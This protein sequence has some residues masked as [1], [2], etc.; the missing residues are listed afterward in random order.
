MLSRFCYAGRGAT[1]KKLLCALLLCALCMPASGAV[2]AQGAVVMDA[3]TG[4]VLFEQNADARLPM[5]STTKIMTAL[6]ALGEGNL[7]RTYTVKA[8]YAQVE[9]SSMYLREGETLTLRDTLYGLML[10]SGNDAAVA[11]AG[12]CGG[13]GNFVQKMNDK[14]VEL[15]LTDTHFDNPNGLPGDTHYTTA[16][17]LAKI[18][19]AALRDPV[20]RQIVST[21]TYT[22]GERTLSN[23]NRL[24]SMYDGAIGVKTG[25]TR[26]AGRC[27]V[28]AAERNGRTLIA[29]T[30]NDPDDWNDHMQMLDAGFAQYEEV[31]LHEAG[32]EIT[33]LRVFG[34]DVDSVPLLAQNTVTAYLLPGEREK[35]Q[36]VRYGE[37]ICYAPVV[38]TAHAGRIEY[39]I[40]DKVLA[41]DTLVYGGAA[42]LPAEEKSLQERILD[43]NSGE[44]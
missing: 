15:G 33:T 37:K 12:E 11:I 28:S 21:Q 13:Y 34:G 31:T 29:V 19:A 40:G 42:L 2:S 38:Q 17:E 43:R 9:G 24:L 32:Q 25:Y 14:A 36:A 22:V 16:R 5:A 30:L 20:F 6:V 44:Y 18:T 27:L 3:D 23:H 7:D 35:I 26:A 1:V 8:E 4:E 39:R 10:E 41:R